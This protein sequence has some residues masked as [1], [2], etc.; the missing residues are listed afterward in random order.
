MELLWLLL[1]LT[2]SLVAY[3]IEKKRWTT[4]VRTTDQQ[5]YQQWCEHLD[6][7][8]IPYQAKTFTIVQGD[9]IETIYKIK[10][11]SQQASQVKAPNVPL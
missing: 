8:D 1:A 10:V 4:L 6:R 5:W 2:C 9:E 7:L 3:L 11:L